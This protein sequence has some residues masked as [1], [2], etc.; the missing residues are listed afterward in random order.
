M[1][2]TSFKSALCN[3]LSAL[4]ATYARLWDLPDSDAE[5]CGRSFVEHMLAEDGRSL[6]AYQPGCCFAAWLRACA[7]NWVKNYR[8]AQV[9]RRQHEIPWPEVISPSGSHLRWDCPDSAQAPEDT[10]LHNEAWK[11]VMAAIGQLSAAQRELIVRHHLDDEAIPELAASTGKTTNAIEQTLHRARQRL[12][13]QLA[14]QGW[15]DT[16]LLACLAPPPLQVLHLQPPLGE[17]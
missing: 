4:A 3:H 10:L 2:D 1:A 16:E 14:R 7:A 5:D 17:D 15:T 6:R 11:C 12:C 8:R 9:R 13:A